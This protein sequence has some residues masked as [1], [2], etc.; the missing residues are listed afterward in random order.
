M[1][2]R[3]SYPGSIRPWYPVELP[4]SYESLEQSSVQGGGRTLEMS[5]AAI[6]FVCDRNLRVGLVVRLAIQW[7][8]KLD[9]GTS[10]SLSA[11]GKIQ[12]SGSWKVEAV[13]LRHEFKAWRSDKAKA[14]SSSQSGDCSAG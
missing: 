9:D 6:R 8:V 1:R 4:V 5:S 12:M 11:I 14:L 3:Q 10:L 2:K 7:P 13:L